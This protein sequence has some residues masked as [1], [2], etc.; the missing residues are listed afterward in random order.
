MKRGASWDTIRSSGQ[1]DWGRGAWKQRFCFLLRMDNLHTFIYNGGIWKVT[2][3]PRLKMVLLF[4]LRKSFTRVQLCS[5]ECML[6]WEEVTQWSATTSS[7]CTDL[8]SQE[9]T[10]HEEI[11]SH[12]TFHRKKKLRITNH[13][14]TFYHPLIIV[15]TLHIL[16]L[17]TF[18]VYVFRTLSVKYGLYAL[19]SKSNFELTKL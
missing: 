8:L 7:V 5:N 11:I 17:L 9:I 14:N 13:E 4:L 2:I 18:T 15:E 1:R 19:K 6:S 16:Y 12:F 3:Q 10:I